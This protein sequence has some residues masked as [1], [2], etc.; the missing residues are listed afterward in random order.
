[1]AIT[2]LRC[3]RNARIYQGHGLATKCFRR[4]RAGL[5][6]RRSSSPTSVFIT[7]AVMHLSY[8]RPR[9][10]RMGRQLRAYI[11]RKGDLPCAYLPS[12]TGLQR[13]LALIRA[14]GSI[15][16]G[17]WRHPSH[18]SPNTVYSQVFNPRS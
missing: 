18:G 3:G 7:L 9:P 13:D 8:F 15:C 14:Y 12:G 5:V 2:V 10:N 17:G 16:L 11:D 1:M 4:G 6:V